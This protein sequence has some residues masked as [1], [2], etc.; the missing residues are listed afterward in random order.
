MVVIALASTLIWARFDGSGPGLR[1][2]PSLPGRAARRDTSADVP[3]SRSREGTLG[4]RP[5]TEP[6]VT[7]GGPADF[8]RAGFGLAAP[9]G[10][11]A[12][13]TAAPR[14]ADSRTTVAGGVGRL[15]PRNR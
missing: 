2:T 4:N 10:P 8:A 5:A 14:P 6:A 13:S 12:I 11:A 7:R 15:R 1:L 3:S 9:A